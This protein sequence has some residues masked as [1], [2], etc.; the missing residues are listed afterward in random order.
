M[1]S[2]LVTAGLA[3]AAVSFTGRAVLRSS[4]AWS[5]ILQQSWK[6]LPTSDSLLGSRYYK[7][8]FEV[9][10]NKREAGLIL[11]V[12]STASRSKLKDAHKRVMLL[13]HPDRGGSPYLA[14]KINEAKDLLDVGKSR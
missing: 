13:N 11:G 2:S 1:A 7:G 4:Q 8:G 3:L 6:S 5:K 14:A 12:S 9:K 10:M